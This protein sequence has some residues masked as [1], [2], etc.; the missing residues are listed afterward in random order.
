MAHCNGG[1]V[2][3]QLDFSFDRSR[4]NR[5]HFVRGYMNAQYTANPD[6]VVNKD[7]RD[8]VSRI[9]ADD[10]RAYCIRNS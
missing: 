5:L 10:F 6:N 9:P 8:A 4:G 7:H 2:Q 1:V 3:S